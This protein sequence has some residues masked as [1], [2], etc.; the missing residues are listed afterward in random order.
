[1]AGIY[2]HIPY[3]KQKCHYC[4]FHFSV[5]LR[6]KDDLI[7]ALKKELILRKDEID[8]AVETIYFGGGTPSLLV[9]Y[10]IKEL[11]DLINNNYDVIKDAE[12]TLEANPDDLTQDYLEKL[13]KTPVNRL[14]IGVQSFFDEDLRFMNRA[15]TAEEAINSIK[16]AQSVGFENITI[17]L[18]YGTPGLSITK[19]KQNLATF[20]ELNIPHLSSYALTVED[21]TALDYFIKTKKIP[22]LND[23]LSKQHFE[24]L[25]S[26]LEDANYWQYELSN[27]AKDS[28]FSKHNSAYWQNKK[29]LG[30]GPSAH[31][32]NTVSRSWNVANNSKYIKLL[33]NNILPGSSESLTLA[34]RYNEY[35]MTGLRT[36]W[37]VSFDRIRLD[38]G[39]KYLDYFKN[40]IEH[41]VTNNQLRIVDFSINLG[42]DKRVTV[43]KE[44]L[45]VIDGI[46]SDLFYID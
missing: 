3:C 46:I 43:S 41:F 8:E 45:F 32:Y 19:W 35:I 4:D 11:L 24:I 1:M 34:D 36:M 9:D 17:D 12:I 21:R 26:T 25:I 18:I 27:F 15:H 5:S 20:L 31:S 39:I 7:R 29:Y 44:A 33:Q 10:E 13:T 16:Y 6:T 30:F 23:A 42:L 14:S 22:P 2:I 38:F 28:F 37:G 40:S